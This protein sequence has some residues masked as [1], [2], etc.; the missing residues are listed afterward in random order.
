MSASRF[1]VPGPWDKNTPLMF[2]EKNSHHAMRV[3]RMRNGDEAEIFDGNGK[4]ASGHLFFSQ[5]GTEFRADEVAEGRAESPVKLRLL[6]AFVSPEKLDW[7]VEKNTEAGVFEIILFPA[8][9]SVTRL[10]G[11]KLEK[12]LAKLQATAAAACEQCGRSR[13]PQVKAAASLE[14]ALSGVTDG[15]RIIL[16]PSAEKGFSLKK[17]KDAA[18]AVGPE[19]GFSEEELALADGLGWSRGLIGPRVLRTETAGLVAV[20]CANALIGD[21]ALKTV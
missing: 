12:R 10:S 3:L 5:A 14:A 1:F 7:I 15:A 19:G 9:R 20:S 4:S 8:A 18:F 21:Y 6:Q 2:S 16:A 17:E 11:D 13:I